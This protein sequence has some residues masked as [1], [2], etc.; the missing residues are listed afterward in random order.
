MHKVVIFI[1]FWRESNRFSG[2]PLVKLK[3]IDNLREVIEIEK[4]LGN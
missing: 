4:N 3:S 1:P 2:K